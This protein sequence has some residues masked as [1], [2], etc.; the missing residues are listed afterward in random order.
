M[1]ITQDKDLTNKFK[2]DTRAITDHRAN[3]TTDKLN[4]S[5]VVE[6]LTHPHLGNCSLGY[7]LSFQPSYEDTKGA[8]GAGYNFANLGFQEGDVSEV[9]VNGVSSE[10]IAALLIDHLRKLQAGTL[11]CENNAAALACFESGLQH[12]LKTPQSVF[13]QERGECKMR[14]FKARPYAAGLSAELK[15]ESELEITDK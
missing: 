2:A 9:G 12:L 1:I 7:F 14:V 10:S 15:P 5:I 4:S 6:E 8:G 11:A 3:G 13:I